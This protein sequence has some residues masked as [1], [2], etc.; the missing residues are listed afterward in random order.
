[1]TN[2][3]D[4]F[5]IGK[6]S[7]SSSS[8]LKQA[9]HSGLTPKTSGSATNHKGNIGGGKSKT[10]PVGTAPIIGPTVRPKNCGC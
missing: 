6:S 10:P 1:M 2:K 7:G 8:K 4:G 9:N 5:D 3:F